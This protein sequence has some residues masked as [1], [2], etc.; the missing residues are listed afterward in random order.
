MF[1]LQTAADEFLH[2]NLSISIAVH[3]LSVSKIVIMRCGSMVHLKYGRCSFFGTSFLQSNNLKTKTVFIT[4]VSLSPAR[5][6]SSCILRR[7]SWPFPADLSPR[8]HPHRTSCTE[9]SFLDRSPPKCPLQFFFWTSPGGDVNC[10][11]EF[12]EIY[13]V[14]LVS[15]K[16]P[17]IKDE[18][19]LQR[20]DE[21]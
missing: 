14:V 5:P 6:P 20:W 1:D 21:T 13:E 3:F 7:Q 18:I 17:E 12:F 15:V 19:I 8:S 11:Q 2:L 9:M 10:Q 16:S 4:D